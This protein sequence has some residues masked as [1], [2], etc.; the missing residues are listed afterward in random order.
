VLARWEL[1][2][3][4][5]LQCKVL[6]FSQQA[7]AAIESLS[8]AAVLAREVGS[9]T[10]DLHAQAVSLAGLLQQVAPAEVRQARASGNWPF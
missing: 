9:S 10:A 4:L 7:G 2:S 8:R 1:A 6:V 3:S 5:L